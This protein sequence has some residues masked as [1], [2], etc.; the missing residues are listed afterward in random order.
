M[1]KVH[2]NFSEAG[3]VQQC[4]GPHAARTHLNMFA[5]SS[6]MNRSLRVQREDDGQ[7]SGGEG[8]TAS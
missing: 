7:I 5:F 8:Q 6:R 2:G 3:T 4:A 1:V